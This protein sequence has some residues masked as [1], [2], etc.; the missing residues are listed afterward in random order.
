MI[1]LS[2]W[3]GFNRR[4]YVFS[5]YGD[6]PEVWQPPGDGIVVRPGVKFVQ[7]PDKDGISS[8]GSS[9]GFG[10]KDES[11]GGSNMVNTLTQ[12]S[13]C[14]WGQCFILFLWQSRT[15]FTWYVFSVL[16]LVIYLL[17]LPFKQASTI[18]CFCLKVSFNGV[19]SR[20]KCSYVHHSSTDH[21][22]FYYAFWV[23]LSWSKTFSLRRWQVSLSI[24]FFF[25]I[26]FPQ[27]IGRYH[28]KVEE[29]NISSCKFY[30]TNVCIF[31]F[32]YSRLS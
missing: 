4:I 15:C 28:Y 20:D 9:G 2:I 19:C 11:W 7:V 1:I 16:C 8:G 31:M 29:K 22:G 32:L 23:F 26:Y 12:W 30:K 6:P 3:K 24:I 13:L 17:Q 14:H 27:L 21:C 10:E 18:I 25:D 5:A